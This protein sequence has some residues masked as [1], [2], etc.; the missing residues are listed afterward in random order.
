MNNGKEWEIPQSRSNF[1][2][3]SNS[4]FI[5]FLDF[6]QCLT[7]PGQ[8]DQSMTNNIA[9]CLSHTHDSRWNWLPRFLWALPVTQ[10]ILP[11]LLH[12]AAWWL[13][14][15]MYC[16]VGAYLYTCFVS[17]DFMVGNFNHNDVISRNMLVI[18]L[19]I[20]RIN[21]LFITRNKRD[22]LTN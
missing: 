5:I 9:Q 4:I 15:Y 22:M 19:L 21:F 16:T 13:Y 3:H 7:S 14:T 20:L 17:H 8:S 12:R 2:I 11:K 6:D 18:S 1:K 10:M